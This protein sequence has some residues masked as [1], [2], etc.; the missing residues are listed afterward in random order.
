MAESVRGDP[1]LFDQ[2]SHLDDSEGPRKETP[3]FDYYLCFVKNTWVSFMHSALVF[4]V[5]HLTNQGFTVCYIVFL[6]TFFEKKKNIM[7]SEK[8]SFFAFSL[9][10][11]Y[12]FCQLLGGGTCFLCLL[13]TLFRLSRGAQN[14]IFDGKTAQKTSPKQQ[15]PRGLTV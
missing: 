5:R 4:A 1:N 13:K 8:N 9:C 15:M 6:G 10:F 14:R 12:V 2:D 3:T 7:L 11:S